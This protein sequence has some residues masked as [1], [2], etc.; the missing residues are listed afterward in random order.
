MDMKK[1]LGVATIYFAVD[2]KFEFKYRNVESE[3]G[4]KKRRRIW[5]SSW[6]EWRYIFGSGMI[7]NELG[8]L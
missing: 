4:A 2:G 3:E 8:S 6:L 5:C 1:H 7:F